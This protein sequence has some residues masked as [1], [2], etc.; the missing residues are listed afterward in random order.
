MVVSIFSEVDVA[1]KS[2]KYQLALNML[3]ELSKDNLDNP[4][5]LYR[6]GVIEERY[7]DLNRA[8][9]LYLRLIKAS[10]N[11]ALPY[12]YSAYVFERLGQRDLAAILYSLADDIDGRALRLKVTDRVS[13]EVVL[14]SSSGK[15]FLSSY[16]RQQ[17]QELTANFP[18]TMSDACWVQL[19][20]KPIPFKDP[21]QKPH[22]F[23]LPHLA[24]KPVYDLSVETWAREL[25]DGS[26]DIAGELQAYLQGERSNV[27][28]YLDQ[29]YIS[30]PNFKDLA[31]SKNWGAIHLYQDGKLNEETAKYFKNT[32]KYLESAPLYGL[33]DSPFEVFFSLLKAGQS[34]PSH[35]GLSNHS[36]T[37]HLP[38]VNTDSAYLEVANKK[39]YWR[40][41]ELLAFDDSF[42]HAANNHGKEE[43]IVLI[44]SIWNPSLESAETEAIQQIFSQ[45][46]VWL[47]QR[48][49]S[50]EQAL[51]NYNKGE[52]E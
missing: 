8:G 19:W 34:I 33:D 50:I 29:N 28:P 4:Q 14:R 36:L 1:L 44:F 21:L 37:V 46:K 49:H 26:H 2:G 18:K 23:Y 35:Y 25:C 30:Q 48:Y 13:E 40:Q 51:K 5:F 45:R 6:Y 39:Y 52:V 20:D 17:H 12:L 43:R 15:R 32:L 42:V 10:P 47:E 22:L 7:G 16:F 27:E 24:P 3:H 41:G 9:Y 38:L 31:G 11:V